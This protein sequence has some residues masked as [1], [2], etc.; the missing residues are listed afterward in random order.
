[1]D[2]S[3]MPL[4]RLRQLEKARDATIGFILKQLDKAEEEEK[5]RDAQNQAATDIGEARPD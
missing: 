1:M 3:A 4:Q 2:Y 5:Q